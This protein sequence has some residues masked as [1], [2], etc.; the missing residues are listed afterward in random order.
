MILHAVVRCWKLSKRD[1]DIDIPK[2]LSYT[3][4]INIVFQGSQN[5]MTS[6][7]GCSMFLYRIGEGTQVIGIKNIKYKS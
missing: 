2:E 6:L 1:I 4:L 5:D 7:C 3:L